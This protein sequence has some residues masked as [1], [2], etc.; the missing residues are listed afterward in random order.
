MKINFPLCQQ[1]EK[2]ASNMSEEIHECRHNLN[3][4][5]FLID[6]S[7]L[8]IYKLMLTSNLSGFRLVFNHVCF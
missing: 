3:I 8:L 7:N 6:S 5:L 4:L 2:I 1:M